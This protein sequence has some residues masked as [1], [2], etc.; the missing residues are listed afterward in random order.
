LI[1]V[2]WFFKLNANVVFAAPANVRFEAEFYKVK[3]NLD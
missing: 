2:D 3:F 1:Q